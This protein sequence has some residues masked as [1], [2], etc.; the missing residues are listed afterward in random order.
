MR[1]PHRWGSG[2]ACGRVLR[3]RREWVQ[4]PFL[5]RGGDSGAGPQRVAP[6]SQ[7]TQC[8]T[9]GLARGSGPFEPPAA[10]EFPP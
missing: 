4:A 5:L 6:G 7:P 2:P 8:M 1:G 3:K 10:G 9:L